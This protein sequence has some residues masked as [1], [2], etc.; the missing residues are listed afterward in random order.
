LAKPKRVK[1]FIFSVFMFT[2]RI[3]ANF[4]VRVQSQ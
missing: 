2:I 4:V 1:E 3:T